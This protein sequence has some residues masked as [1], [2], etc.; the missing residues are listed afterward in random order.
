M[1]RTN[2]LAESGIGPLMVK[3][4]IP[5]FIG[6]LANTL[7]NIVDRIFIGQGVG[8]MALSGISVTFPVM[9]IVMG[10]GMLA[11]GI[12]KPHLGRVTRSYSP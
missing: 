6:V 7:Y 2:E 1:D 5:A 12:P 9:L 11:T 10:F 8:S 4:Y 3:F